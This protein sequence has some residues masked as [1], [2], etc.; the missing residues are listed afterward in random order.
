MGSADGS[1]RKRPT[2]KER[3]LVDDLC[4]EERDKEWQEYVR[5][6]TDEIQQTWTEED[7]ERHRLI[8]NPGFSLIE[9]NTRPSRRDFRGR[10]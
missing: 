10:G 5:Q 1:K 9:W 3:K 7:F 2:A 8:H 4:V 6:M